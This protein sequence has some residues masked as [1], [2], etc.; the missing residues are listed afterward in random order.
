MT[1]TQPETSYKWRVG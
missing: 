1:I